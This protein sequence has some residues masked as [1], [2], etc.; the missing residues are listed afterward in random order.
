L[1][2]EFV[3]ITENP[4]KKGSVVFATVFFQRINIPT[5]L[6]STHY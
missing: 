4:L 6:L 2:K 3:S 5:S 1:E